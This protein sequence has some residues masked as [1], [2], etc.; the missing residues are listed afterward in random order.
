MIS[1]L[2][3]HDIVQDKPNSPW[4]IN[5]YEFENLLNSLKEQ[6]CLFCGFDNISHDKQNSIVLTFDDAPG[7]AINWVIKRAYIFDVQVAIFPIVNWL[8]FPDMRFPNCTYRSLATWK[9]IN[10]ANEL[11]H[12]IGSH[13][14]SHVPMHNLEKNKIVY[15]LNESKKIFENKLGSKINHFS[16][17]FGKLSPLVIDLAFEIGYTSICSTVAGT[18]TYRDISSSVL[19]RFVI[20]SDF[21]EFGLP[22]DLIKK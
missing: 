3:I 14:M 20:R 15:E 21:P 7:G 5:V 18:N 6:D 9:D 11:G 12:I 19:K 17:P 22:N 13:G 8:D 16:A 10:Q 4:E 1:I 2:C